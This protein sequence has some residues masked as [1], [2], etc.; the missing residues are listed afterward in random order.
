MIKLIHVDDDPDVREIV[1]I[2]LGLSG[3][4]VVLQC[5][6]GEDALAQMGPYGPDVLLFDFMLPGM[7]GAQT[8]AE[9]RKQPEFRDIPA[10]Y[11]TGKTDAAA[12]RAYK[13]AGINGV[14]AKPFDPMTIADEIKR[15]MRTPV[16]VD[17]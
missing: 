4:F 5:E 10:I 1:D 15:L 17:A 3:E 11:M 12:L 16:K 2:S 13:E 14:I 6:T 9:A 8:L 7:S